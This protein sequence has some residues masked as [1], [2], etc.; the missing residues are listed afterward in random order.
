GAGADDGSIVDG[1]GDQCDRWILRRHGHAPRLRPQRWD[2]R[3][4]GDS[5][6]VTVDTRGVVVGAAAGT[7]QELLHAVAVGVTGRVD[8]VVVRRAAM[9]VVVQP[10]VGSGQ[11]DGLHVGMVGVRVGVAAGVDHRDRVPLVLEVQ[12]VHVGV[13]GVVVDRGPVGHNTRKVVTGGVVLNGREEAY[14]L[15]TLL[16]V[17]VRRRVTMEHLLM[18]V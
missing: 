5:S 8:G 18:S 9:V 16:I 3:Q 10:V 11:G 14:A 15:G 1:L 13:D 4:D 7:D 6:I 12:V 2:P 17:C